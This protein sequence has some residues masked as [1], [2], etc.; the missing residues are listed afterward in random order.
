M[1]ITTPR[2]VI[3]PVLPGDGAAT[4]EAVAETFDQL[5]RWMLWTSEGLDTPEAIE[6]NIRQ[7]HAEFILRKDFRMNAYERDGE[8]LVAFTGLHRPDWKLRRFEIGY[9]V[10]QSAQGN[11]YAGEVANAMARYAFALMEARR[12][13]ISHAEGN[14]PSRAT[15]EKL[16]FHYEGRRQ[17][18]QALPDGSIVDEHR[19]A[20]LSPD[21]LPPL[22]VHWPPGPPAGAP[23]AGG[24]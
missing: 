5:R 17:S 15:I 4:H 8:R 21:P 9:W 7:A 2:L 3:R 19:Y 22:H 13:E 24:R 12:V 20:L 23:D 14:A 16:G 1:P 11:G 6:A 10:R 18:A